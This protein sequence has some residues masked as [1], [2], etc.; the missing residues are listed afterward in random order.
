MPKA[1]IK[2][3]FGSLEGT[4]SKRIF[5]KTFV[6]FGFGSLTASS[7]TTASFCACRQSL[8]RGKRHGHWNDRFASLCPAFFCFT[9][10]EVKPFYH[11]PSRPQKKQ[12]HVHQPC[13]SFRNIYTKITQFKFAAASRQVANGGNFCALKLETILTVIPFRRKHPSFYFRDRF[14]FFCVA[15]AQRLSK[16]G[17]QKTWPAQKCGLWT[18]GTPILDGMD[19]MALPILTFICDIVSCHQS[20]LGILAHPMIQHS[21]R[22]WIAPSLFNYI[23]VKGMPAKPN[24]FAR[25]ALQSIE[26][27][28]C[29]V[30]IPQTM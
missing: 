14:E 12:K 28:G 3:D 9:Q 27:N 15:P 29:K 19:S 17:R 4:L 24:N 10:V 25:D 6:G 16:I 20:S 11:G 18:L 21:I 23:F 1:E 26:T 22:S 30:K 8:P 5:F 13:I 2:L 7:V